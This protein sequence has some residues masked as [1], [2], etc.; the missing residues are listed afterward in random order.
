MLH[1]LGNNVL[2]LFEDIR[3]LRGS[4]AAAP[5]TSEK[6]AAAFN[7][8]LDVKGNNLPSWLLE[9]KVDLLQGLIFSLWHKQNPEGLHNGNSTIE[10]KGQTG[11]GHSILHGGEVV[12]DNERR[13]EKQAGRSCHAVGSKVSRINLGGNNPGETGIAAE[14]AHVQCKPNE[15]AGYGTGR[16]GC[17][18]DLVANANDDETDE[19]AGKHSVGPEAT[20]KL[21]HVKA[22]RDGTNEQRATANKRHVSRFLVVEANLLHE[23]GHVV[24]DGVDSGKLAEENHDVGVDQGAAGTRDGEEVHPRVALVL[25]TFGDD[26][27]LIQNRHLHD[28]ELL[29]GL[30]RSDAANALPHLVCVQSPALVHQ[31][32]RRLGKEEHAG[33]H[34]GREDERRTEDPTPVARDVNENG[35]DGV[36]KDLT[37][38]NVELIE[39]DD[40]S[41]DSSLGCL[42]DVYRD[43]TALKTD[44]QTQDNSC[45]DN[46]T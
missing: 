16:V 35:G 19:E 24:H 10:A 33:E 7:S 8:V 43:G 46:H 38:C 23:D 37:K 40:I 17:G 39:R 29:L 14:E 44:T 2:V 31:V 25:G 36:A 22:S 15:V 20:T 30:W 1:N 13:Q 6:V 12:G 32:T 4:S 28:E 11:T 18:G 42:G 21:L 41:T 45:S 3:F 5:A 9:E 26:L 27:L 34:D